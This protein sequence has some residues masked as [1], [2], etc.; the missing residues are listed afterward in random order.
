MLRRAR[1]AGLALLGFITA[2]AAEPDN[3]VALSQGDQVTGAIKLGAVQI[4]LPDG[5]WTVAGLGR[6]PFDMPAIGAYGT[7]QSAILFRTDGTRIVAVLEANANLLPVNDGWG[8]T[9]ACAKGEQLRVLTRYKSGWQTG[10]LF[11]QASQFD[12]NSDGPG[13][14]GAARAYARTAG[15]SMPGLWITAGFRNSDRHDLIDTRYHYDPSLFLGQGAAR[16]ASTADWTRESVANDPLRAAAVQA[17]IGWADGYD[18]FV[19]RGLVNQLKTDGPAT[20]M[21]PDAAAYASTSPRADA[22]LRALDGLYRAGRLKWTDYLEQSKAV[23][24]EAPV[25]TD[26]VPLLS[27]AVRKNISFRTFG[28]FVDYLIG[29][30]VTANHGISTGIALSV[31]ATDS[32]W[33]VLND[34]Y[35]DDYYARLNTHDSERLVDF[36]YIGGG[37]GT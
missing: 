18:V 12:L 30:M 14:W 7:I 4:P 8:R 19:D 27:N 36:I 22:R 9:K 24:A 35:W 16:L 34:Q 20:G 28:T 31:N 26:A 37:A 32:V 5:P 29:Y 15:L 10:C 33:F 25:V 3:A 17:V 21:M 2:L 13:A 1:R 6:Q 11:V 23:A